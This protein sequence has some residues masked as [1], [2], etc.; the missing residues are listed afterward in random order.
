MPSKNHKSI[1][2][3]NSSCVDMGQSVL[4]LKVMNVRV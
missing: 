2:V 4:D 1:R 3:M